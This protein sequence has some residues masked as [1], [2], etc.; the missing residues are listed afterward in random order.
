[1]H[2]L[3]K[4][5]SAHFMGNFIHTSMISKHDLER[6][7]DEY[8][9][10]KELKIKLNMGYKKIISMLN[11]YEIPIKKRVKTKIKIDKDELKKLYERYTISQIASQLHCDH[12]T[13]SKLFKKYNLEFKQPKIKR[14]YTAQYDFFNKC[15]DNPLALYW[16]GF[17]AADGNVYK[18]R[19][20]IS[21]STKDKD[22]ISKFKKDI[23]SDHPIVEYTVKN[24][25]IN[26]N[27]K[28][29]INSSI[30]INSLQLVNDLKKH[31]GILPNKSLTFTT[32]PKI[33]NSKYVNVFYR[34]YFDGDG[35]WY[36]YKNKLTFT[37]CGSK[38]F[39][40]SFI[41]L[42]IY[43]KVIPSRCKNN[44]LY[45]SGKIY[46]LK[47]G[48]NIICKNIANWLYKDIKNINAR[49]LERKFIYVKN[50][51]I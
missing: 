36:I 37:L 50:Y 1:M 35:N 39:L 23:K 17:I 16:L 19:L 11:A 15:E 21:L 9:T 27:R 30:R 26:I 33:N 47:F 31:G 24:S 43:H 8:G 14:K 7:Y 48:G 45:K 42:L 34:G 4:D 13:I 6:L 10:I 18:T 44:K 3:T 46:V 41:R 49:C 28:D 40:I 29:T 32:L 2:S 12:K 51:I 5:F 38:D 22:H 25:R 20:T